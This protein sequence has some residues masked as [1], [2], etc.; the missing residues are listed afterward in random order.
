MEGTGTKSDA[1][2][3]QGA[4]IPG[5]GPAQVASPWPLAR[6]DDGFTII[7]SRLTSA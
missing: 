3:M 4:K 7:L 6:R 5:Y 2:P 1:S